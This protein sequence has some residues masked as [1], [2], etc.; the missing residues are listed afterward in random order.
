MQ[1]LNH[2]REPVILA[3]D[4]YALTGWYEQVLGFQRVQLVDG[5]YRYAVLEVPGKIRL[6]FGE[7]KPMGITTPDP[8]NGT[9]RL[10]WEVHPLED[11]MTWF[12]ERGGEVVFGPSKDEVDNFMY[13]AIRDPEGNEIWLVDEDCP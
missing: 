2:S 1:F 12:T 8:A 5:A 11:F 10:Q 9:V 7:A 3:Q 13:G 6:G 4:F